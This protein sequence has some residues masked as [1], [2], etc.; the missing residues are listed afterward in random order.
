MN[1][2]VY[3][4]RQNKANLAG[5]LPPRRA[6]CAKRTQFFDCGLRKA[7]PICPATAGGTRPAGRG[8]ADVVQTNP[9]S[10]SEMCE[11]KPIWPVGPDLGGQNMRNKPNARSGAPRRC[12]RL[13]IGDCRASLAMTCCGSGT[14]LSRGQPAFAGASCTNKPN[15]RDG[16]WGFSLDPPP[17]R[18]Q[19]DYA[20][21]SQLPEAGHRGGVRRYRAGRAWAA[22]QTNPIRRNE[23]RQTNPISAAG[24]EEASALREMSYGEL[25]TSQALAK[26]SQFGPPCQTNPIGPVGRSPEG[27]IGKTKSRLVLCFQEPDTF[28]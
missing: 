8:T 14:G 12:L 2:T 4:P 15:F 17:R 9:I 1:R 21:Q 16:V 27:E 6:K 22:V 11:T 7:K 18:C 28:V 23:L 19:A 10:W 20:K 5:R 13:R 24:K 3:R 25:H 26:Q